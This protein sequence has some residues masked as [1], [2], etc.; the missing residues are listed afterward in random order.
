MTHVIAM[1]WYTARVVTT[2]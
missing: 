2:P 1:H